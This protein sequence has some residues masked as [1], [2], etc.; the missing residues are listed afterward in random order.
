MEQNEAEI[1][2]KG[3]TAMAELGELGHLEPDLAMDM[4]DTVA[5]DEAVMSKRFPGLTRD[6][7]MSA[8]DGAVREL[9]ADD[10]FQVEARAVR[11]ARSVSDD[12]LASSVGFPVGRVRS[13]LGGDIQTLTDL[14]DLDRINSM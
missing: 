2:A 10:S 6:D 13:L 14:D 7:L 11:R 8:Y 4:I 3:L 9:V 1:Y 12:Y 5:A